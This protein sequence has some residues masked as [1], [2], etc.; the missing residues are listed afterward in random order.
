MI[1]APQSLFITGTDTEIG[2]TTVACALARAWVDAGARVGAMKP[3]AAGLVNGESEDLVA[4]EASCNIRFP[5]DLACPYPLPDPIAPHLAAARAGVEIRVDVIAA[6]YRALVASAP[7]VR[8]IEK[9]PFS[10]FGA[11]AIAAHT[12]IIV[13]GA[14]GAL[15]PLN[16]SEDMLTIA[17]L[18]DLPVLLVV[19]MRLGCISHALLT[20][21]VIAARG[22]PLAGWIGNVLDPNM[23]FL[24]ENVETLKNRIHAPFWGVCGFGGELV[25]AT[26]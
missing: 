22:L 4:L 3:I 11:D 12:A 8:I 19:G 10:T 24:H 17:A 9:T 1:P 23:P 5:R 2:K 13:E 18:C 7:K 25:F 21:Q 26:L 15:V 14:G 6:A 16:E 20:A